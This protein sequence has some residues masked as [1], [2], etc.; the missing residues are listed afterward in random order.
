L[1]ALKPLI[2][3]SIFA[4]LVLLAYLIEALER[5]AKSFACGGTKLP[6]QVYRNT[7][8]YAKVG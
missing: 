3:L 5:R 2:H 6:G 8:S 4:E 1:L 7:L